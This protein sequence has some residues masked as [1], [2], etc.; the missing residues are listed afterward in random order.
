MPMA[1]PIFIIHFLIKIKS[2]NVIRNCKHLWQW[3]CLLH[4]SLLLFLNSWMAVAEAVLFV[5][6][7]LP[8]SIR[9][10]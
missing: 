10:V 3:L 2:L 4:E 9:N 5:I 1:I 6:T 8:S 7:I